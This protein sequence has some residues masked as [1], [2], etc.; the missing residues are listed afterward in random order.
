MQLNIRNTIVHLMSQDLNPKLLR[1]MFNS[2]LYMKIGC[3]AIDPYQGVSLMTIM[4]LTSAQACIGL[5]CKF[6]KSL[7][8]NLRQSRY[9]GGRYICL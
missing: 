3:S 9:D 8:Y 6:L 2:V 7:L 1:S 4:G 5:G